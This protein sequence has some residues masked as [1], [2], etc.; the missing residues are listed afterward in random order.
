MIDGLEQ[1]RQ[2]INPQIQQRAAREIHVRHAVRRAPH[3]FDV[4]AEGV[5]GYDAVDGAELAGLD[6]GADL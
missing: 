2:A 6:E 3:V 5:V 4:D 1:P